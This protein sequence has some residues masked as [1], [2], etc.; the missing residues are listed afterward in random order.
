[1]LKYKIY[2]LGFLAGLLLHHTVAVWLVTASYRN[3]GPTRLRSMIK[4]RD[5]YELGHY[6]DKLNHLL[7]RVEG[8]YLGVGLLAFGLIRLGRA[9]KAGDGA[10]SGRGLDGGMCAAALCGG[11]AVLTITAYPCLFGEVYFDHDLGDFHLPFRYFYSHGLRD[12]TG[13]LW[14][15][16]I[17]GGL[18]LHGEGQ[19]GMLHP[20][21][22][23]I[24]RS[25]PWSAAFNVEILLGYLVL[26]SGWY[27][28]FRR[29]Q[30]SPGVSALTAMV[31]TLGASGFI[32]L[33]HLNAIAI[34]AQIPWQLYFADRLF[35]GRAAG[36]MCELGIALCTASQVL[37]G[38]PQYLWFSGLVEGAYALAM[39]G[40]QGWRLALVRWV[41]AKS[42]GAS[43]G[44]IQLL[45]TL[46]SLRL[47]ER[48]VPTI[49]FKA[50]DSLNPI[51][52]LQILSPY[53]FRLS[54]EAMHPWEYGFYLGQAAPLVIVW[55]IRDLWADR[56]RRRLIAFA[57]AVGLA[58]FV[59]S[60]G[61]YSPTFALTSSLPGFNIFRGPSRYSLLLAIG[62]STTFAVAMTDLVHRPPGMRASRKARIVA[63]IAVAVYALLL[64]GQVAIDPK[65]WFA[66]FVSHPGVL[67][68]S[69]CGMIGLAFLVDR[70][71]RGSRAALAVVIAWLI[72]DLVIYD[73]N[74][75]TTF[76]AS[77]PAGQ[78]IAEAAAEVQPGPAGQPV[79][80]EGYLNTNIIAIVGRLWNVKGYVGLTP[81]RKLDYRDK[82]A[83]QVAGV[84]WLR[85]LGGVWS[86]PPLDPLPAVRLLPRAVV[87]DDPMGRLKSVDLATTAIVDHPIELDGEA[88]GRVSGIA[89]RA[90]GYA[91]ETDSVGSQI[92][93]VAR[94]YHPGWRAEV[95]GRPTESIRVYGDFLGCRV[96]GGRHLVRFIWSPKGLL[97]GAAIS[98]AALG[99]TV[100]YVTVG[101]VIWRRRALEV[102]E[103]G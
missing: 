47:S 8:G 18:D 74:Y 16:Y 103:A 58:G 3:E 86:R 20:L 89:D 41:V 38:Y 36:P 4:D 51:Y 34:I 81:S 46:E 50:I 94:N 29:W 26:A 11:L 14:C 31:L 66:P 70:S 2:L 49:G 87:S 56:E 97:N 101:M 96:E 55:G 91:F 72:V 61:N 59:L 63:G 33:N 13:F 10:E 7:Y 43:M 67:L 62:M 48:S 52:Y 15:P 22:L 12:A 21:H 80:I 5:H 54:D 92:L 93:L 39:I 90:A 35:R 9:T 1:M 102:K 64:L 6:L 71:S 73:L 76:A 68:V 23:A 100:A 25:L 19:V 82:L 45:P 17:L 57:A 69:L 88:P 95:D 78:V 84:H 83:R 27:V 42:L 53:F 37:L 99:L 32:K 85:S 44:A 40:T 77:A 65:E 24:Y 98:L 79:L 60:L 30:I 28:F 75:L